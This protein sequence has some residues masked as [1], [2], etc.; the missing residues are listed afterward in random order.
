MTDSADRDARRKQTR[1]EAIRATI[2]GKSDTDTQTSNDEA[3]VVNEDS[4]NNQR[5]VKDDSKMGRRASKEESESDQVRDRRN[6]NMYLDA[7]T[8]RQLDDLYEELNRQHQEAFSIDLPKNKRYYPL[9]VR[10]GV[11]NPEQ[12]QKEL[13]LEED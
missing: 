13:R 11:L 12:I 8:R 4:E 5:D 6:V 10:H 7:E 2:S 3:D 9:V 1:G